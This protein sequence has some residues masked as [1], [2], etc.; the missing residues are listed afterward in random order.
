MIVDEMFDFEG[1]EVCIYIR[2][3]SE[4]DYMSFGIFLFF[5]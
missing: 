2:V 1:L 5:L 4:E 3:D